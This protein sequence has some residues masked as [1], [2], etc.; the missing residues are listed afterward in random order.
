MLRLLLLFLQ[1]TNAG[2]T[3]RMTSP[4]DLLQPMA[5]QGP[6][7]YNDL[8][9]ARQMAQKEHKYILLNFSGSDWCGPCILLR[10]EI[11]DDPVFS[12]MADT[13]LVLVNADFPR[14]KKNQLATAQQKLNDDM[15]DRYDPKGLFPLTL[16]LNAEGKVLTQWE[17]NPGI[18]PEEFSRQIRTIIA[19]DR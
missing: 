16:L 5:A 2:T 14:L 1:L 3:A 8:Q 15:A 4:E 10:K 17:G 11:F 6:T 13:T 9:A 19:T 7:W 18:K 12:K